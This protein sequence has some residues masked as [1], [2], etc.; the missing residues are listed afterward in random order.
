M[1]FLENGSQKL[2]EAIEQNS[3]FESQ[4][5][6][7]LTTLAGW[8]AS[9]GKDFSNTPKCANKSWADAYSLNFQDSTNAQVAK[10][11][12]AMRTYFPSDLPHNHQF[13][14]E[15]WIG[16]MWF[17][18]AARSCGANLTRTCVEKYMNRPTPYLARGLLIPSVSFQLGNSHYYNGLTK[19]C[20]SA[21]QWSNSAN[22][23][24]TRATPASNCYQS[25]AYSYTL[26]SPT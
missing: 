1:R 23:W 17:T 11:N 2:C 24:I 5:K 16:A 8:G 9:V 6:I 22:R 3:A 4:M 15:G 25:R 18:D 12:A 10:Y 20:V 14:F 13:A 7:K 19:Q 21:A 26:T